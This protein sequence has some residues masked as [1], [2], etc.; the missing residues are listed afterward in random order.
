MPRNAIIRFYL[1]GPRS[2][3]H[4]TFVPITKPDHGYQPVINC[5]SQAMLAPFMAPH[6]PWWFLITVL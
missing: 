5:Q 3:L 6:T 2:I 4:K 1:E